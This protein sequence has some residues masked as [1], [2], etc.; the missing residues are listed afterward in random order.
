[1]KII[2]P[3]VTIASCLA[4]NK[5]YDFNKAM[6]TEKPSSQYDKLDYWSNDCG[7]LPNNQGLNE[8]NYEVLYRFN[9]LTVEGSAY[10]PMIE[11]ILTPLKCDDL[12]L[13]KAIEKNESKG[14]GKY[15]NDKYDRKAQK[16]EE[17]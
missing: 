3:C 7:P 14:Y 15:N 16:E 17:K 5:E 12:G 1:M 8:D 6:N 2:F 10:Y 4:W 9:R 11:A 13:N